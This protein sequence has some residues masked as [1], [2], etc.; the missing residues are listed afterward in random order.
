[1]E[2]RIETVIAEAFDLQLPIPKCVKEV[3]LRLL[4][5]ER[6]DL[7]A[8]PPIPWVSTENVKPFGDKIL[9]WRPR[10]GRNLFLKLFHEITLHRGDA[11]PDS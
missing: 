2:K 4:A 9:P 3:D 6:R 7:M 1:M 11:N 8:T 5:T 10:W